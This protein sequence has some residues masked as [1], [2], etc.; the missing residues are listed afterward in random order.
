MR[1][2]AIRFSE[3]NQTQSRNDLLRYDQNKSVYKGL[4]ILNTFNGFGFID[5]DS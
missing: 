3:I 1:F 4:K 5:M 2:F